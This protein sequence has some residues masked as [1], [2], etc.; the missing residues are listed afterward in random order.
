MTAWSKQPI[1]NCAAAFLCIATLASGAGTRIVRA[2]A[3]TH[4]EA[5]TTPLW[6]FTTTSD[7][8][9]FQLVSVDPPR[10]V[11]AT[12]DALHF[13]D[14]TTGKALWSRDDLRKVPALHFDVMDAGSA[15]PIRLVRGIALADDV[16]HIFD[17]ETGAK[18]A[19][20]GNW[21]VKSVC[22][23]LPVYQQGLVLVFANSARGN[24]ALLGVELQSGTVRWRREDVFRAQPEMQQVQIGTFGLGVPLYIATL[25]GN[26]P[27]LQM[28]S[29]NLLLY[30][31][32]DGPFDI[33]P[34]TG[35][36]VW[37]GDVLKKKE[38]PGIAA[39]YAPILVEQGVAYV[40]SKHTLVALNASNGTP[41][42]PNAPQ[43]PGQIVQM[44]WTARG[45]LVA[46][47]KPDGY[48]QLTRDPFLALLNPAT[49]R[50]RWPAR[51]TDLKD[52]SCLT[53]QGDTAYV[54][55]NKKLVAID[56]ASGSVRDIATVTFEG[57]EQ[58]ERVEVRPDGILLISAH[59]L[60]L[61]GAD[62]SP[63]YRRYY[64]APGVGFLA[65][66]GS[67]LLNKPIS[68]PVTVW[69]RD[70][71]YIFTTA[72]DDSAHQGVSLVRVNKADGA[73]AGRI[74]LTEK[75]FDYQTDPATDMVYL[76]Q[77]S[78]AIVA[79]RFDVGTSAPAQAPDR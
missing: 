3:P 27:P 7:I 18:L 12:K 11:V 66:F 8:T 36:T 10:L 53:V 79:L 35:K 34:A 1:G 51:V 19:E 16:M 59:N 17:L 30:L 42:W 47:A 70:F 9:F 46:G 14:A 68:L 29:A 74:W 23:Y 24:N 48:G 28:D 15:D 67:A 65:A 45:L 4:V 58:P 64:P 37:S 20:S 57:R 63:K 50:F 38:V 73:E 41:L 69:D 61:L 33:N 76:K 22:C 44:E 62:G 21:S 26:Q 54:A 75:S 78:R 32:K 2:D 39:G 13:V 43:L 56:L 60:L 5:D 40:P 31:S 55:V 77:G 52:P 71:V 49:G 25:F 72:P 6:R